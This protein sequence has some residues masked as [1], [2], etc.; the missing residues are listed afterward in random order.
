ML[1]YLLL[2]DDYGAYIMATVQVSAHRR[3]RKSA[4]PF[5][6]RSYTQNRRNG[7]KR[8]K[9]GYT[10]CQTK[11]AEV[12]AKNMPINATQ[13]TLRADHLWRNY[14]CNCTDSTHYNLVTGGDLSNYVYRDNPEIG[15]DYTYNAPNWNGKGT[16]KV[17]VKGK[18]VLKKGFT[19]QSRCGVTIEIPPYRA[20]L[21]GKQILRLTIGG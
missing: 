3:G 2:K 18:N 9:K 17:T 4:T 12:Y 14:V 13:E 1:H 15:A 8:K 20:P 16:H 21:T 5:Q 6:V 7:K 19:V 11:I 10:A